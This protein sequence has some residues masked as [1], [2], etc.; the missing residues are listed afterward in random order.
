[1]IKS[2]PDLSVPLGRELYAIT[3]SYLGALTFKLRH[4]EIERHF[5][6]LIIIQEA[7][8]GITQK[9][10]A[11]ILGIDKVTA[12]NMVSYLS[13]KKFVIKNVNAEDRRVSFLS[14]SDK[15]KKAV[16]EIQ[17][18]ISEMNREAFSDLSDKEIW[19]FYAS[20]DKIGSALKTLPMEPVQYRIRKLKSKKTL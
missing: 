13:E 17:R 10:F 1:M 20:L 7:G 5:Y 14:L 6:P 8:V 11:E 19:Q 18:A 12:T 4:M 16:P 2:D 3:K 15:G 9:R